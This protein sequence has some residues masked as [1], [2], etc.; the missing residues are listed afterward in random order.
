MLEGYQKAV[1]G[2]GRNCGL[3][4]AQGSDDTRADH[5]RDLPAPKKFINLLAR[6]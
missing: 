4:R 2:V 5:R 1:S 3:V 6:R